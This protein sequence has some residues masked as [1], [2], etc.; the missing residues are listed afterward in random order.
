MVKVG[1]LEKKFG[2]KTYKFAFRNKTKR[3]IDAHKNI[4]DNYAKNIGA[5][6]LYRTI[7]V[8]DNGRTWYYLYRRYEK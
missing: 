6:I 4:L 5:K 2:G 3:M 1:M 8:K 7:K